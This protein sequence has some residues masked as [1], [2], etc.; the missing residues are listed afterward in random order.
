MDG[1]MDGWV[2]GWMVGWLNECIVTLGVRTIVDR[3]LFFAEWYLILKVLAISSLQAP[4]TALYVI[5]NM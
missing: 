1:W 2:G 5:Y 3:P 4:S